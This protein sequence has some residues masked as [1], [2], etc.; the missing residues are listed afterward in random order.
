MTLNDETRTDRLRSAL[1]ASDASARLNAALA[2]GMQPAPGDVEVLV[3]RCAVEDDFY[4]RDMLTWALTQHDKANTT[5]RL[6]RELDS[7]I[8][9][10]R[11]QALHTL[12][13]T[14]DER[15]W[16]A[17]TPALLADGDDEVARAAWRAAVTLVPDGEQARLAEMLATQLGR[18]DRATQSSLSRA[19][20]A[21]GEASL[22][23]IA[24]AKN[25][26]AD[27]VRMHA[28]ATERL[29]LHPEEGF[30]AAIAEARRVVAL[31][32]APGIEDS[33]Q[34]LLT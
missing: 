21:L 16:P 34:A 9:Q 5:D 24:R 10:A 30:D 18:G 13:K 3:E 14:G 28:L 26:D 6:V 27:G 32:G 2:A 11:S 7:E 23:V 20:A 17:L 29:M 8:P 19:F 4:V 25:A 15:A 22:P 1:Q 12:S 31:R 33:D